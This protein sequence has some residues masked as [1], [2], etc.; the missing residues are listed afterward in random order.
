MMICGRK[1][2]VTELDPV[3]ELFREGENVVVVTRA[4]LAGI[5][6]QDPETIRAIAE[7]IQK[8]ERARLRQ[9]LERAAGE[10]MP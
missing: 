4:E 2:V 5:H 1:V 10:E 6:R 7:A 9:M 8:C 3:P